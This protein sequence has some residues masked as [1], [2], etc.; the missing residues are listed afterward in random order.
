MA[1]KWD[2]PVAVYK[3]TRWR[4]TLFACVAQRPDCGMPLKRITGVPAHHQTGITIYQDC[5]ILSLLADFEAGDIRH[6]CGIGGSRGKVSCQQVLRWRLGMTGIGGC[7]ACTGKTTTQ[8]ETP[9]VPG[10]T[11]TAYPCQGSFRTQIHRQRYRKFAATPSPAATSGTVFP[12]SAANAT[13][14]FLNSAAYVL[15]FM[16]IHIS[17]LISGVW[18]NL[19]STFL[20]QD[21]AEAL[22]CAHLVRIGAQI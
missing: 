10:D 16:L 12:A 21:Q 9:N 8:P 18:L 1:G 22:G 13:A 19:V 2:A 4:T 5:E 11:L 7:D 14:S 6:P 3:Q 20:R 15:R 17:F